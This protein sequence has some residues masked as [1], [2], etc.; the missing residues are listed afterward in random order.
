M[1]VIHTERENP[2]DLPMLIFPVGIICLVIVFALRLWYLQIV[3]Y[4]EA[5]R[6]AQGIRTK[7]TQISAPRGLI[8]DVK[9]RLIAGV[10]SQYVVT[11]PPN[12][13]IKDGTLLKRIG[14][15]LGIPEKDL[16]A[17]LTERRPEV[18]SRIPVAIAEGITEAQATKIVEHHDLQ[19]VE[20]S[21]KPMRYYPVPL[22]F[23]H[24]LG[25]A[26]RPSDRDKQR[27][28]KKDIGLPDLVGK[29]GIEYAHDFELIGEPGRVTAS[30]NEE[31][32]IS[33]IEVVEKS[34]PGSKLT[35]GLDIDLQNYAASLLGDRSGAV[36]AVEPATGL[37]LCYVSTPSYDVNKW[38]KPFP[39]AAYKVIDDDPEKPFLDRGASIQVAPGSTF[40][41]VTALA[42]YMEG[43]FD[44]NWSVYCNRGIKV[45][46]RHIKCTGFHGSVTYNRAMASSCN[47]YFIALGLK[48]G[49][50]AIQ[51]AARICGYGEKTGI[52]LM[53]ENKGL[54]PTVEW[55]QLFMPKGEKA[56][57]YRGDTANISIGQGAMEAT[58]IQLANMVAFFAN[59]GKIYRPHF[60]KLINGKQMIEPEVIH[61]YEA[62]QE[63]WHLVQQSLSSVTRTGTARG[64]AIA[65]VDMAGK[66][67][68]AQNSRAKKTDSIFVG[69]AP[70]DNPK[71][72]I[73][74]LAQNAGHGGEVAA[75]IA[76]KVAD[77]YLF[78]PEKQQPNAKPSKEPAPLAQR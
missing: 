17:N 71:I 12:E 9:G 58:P 30:L 66:T 39:T 40:K 37:V 13:V 14:K 28:F 76:A 34:Q 24:A 11:V 78:P 74:V 75:P 10:R 31:N 16:L 20:V 62:S 56:Q 70:A 6:S 7:R 32:E 59:R 46:N 77:F 15:V 50:D 35:L 67:G 29:S 41:M 53:S 44:P 55:K 43:K 2:V 45:G 19:G 5:V 3:N 27:Y 73:A 61:S 69:Y 48:A 60:V 42:A 63:F 72:A 57:W 65:R 51:N 1:S 23:T 49:P 64:S 38:L 68:S 52:D 47:A 4:D 18:R 54:V 33:S 26:R 22:N 21:L 36:V 8:T 25:Y